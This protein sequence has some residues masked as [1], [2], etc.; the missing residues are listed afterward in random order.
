M[1]QKG[2]FSTGFNDQPG[3]EGERIL[4]SYVA[5]DVIIAYAKSYGAVGWGEV[6]NPNSYQL[7][8]SGDPD[9]RLN[10]THLHQLK[11]VWKAVASTLELG[12]R[13]EILR[14]DFSIYHPVSTSVG[15]DNDKA[16]KLIIL[17]TVTNLTFGNL[18]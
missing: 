13:P 7:L 11:I 10:G 12:I 15:I 17:S 2:Q 14:K 3:D 18:E 1:V 5:G 16:K 6:E 4:K 9:D 8:A